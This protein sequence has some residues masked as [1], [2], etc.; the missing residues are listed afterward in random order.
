MR[1][2]ALISLLVTVFIFSQVIGGGTYPAPS[3]NVIRHDPAYAAFACL[4]IL[5]PESRQRR[6][7]Q[8][9]ANSIICIKGEVVLPNDAATAA[10]L[11]STSATSNNT[12]SQPQILRLADLDKSRTTI[13]SHKTSTPSSI[14]F[15]Q[16]METS[17]VWPPSSSSSPQNHAQTAQQ[18]PP[19]SSSSSSAPQAAM[20]LRVLLGSTG[21]T[22]LK[23]IVMRMVSGWEHCGEASVV[24]GGGKGEIRWER[25]KRISIVNTGAL[26]G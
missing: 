26:M 12:P 16:V 7:H 5:T 11:H 10:A 6:G 22:A 1:L 2:C 14:I 20:S 24:L 8:L 3:A 17:G 13:S 15:L 23:A 9:D 18:T 4:R 19:E 21:G 25:R